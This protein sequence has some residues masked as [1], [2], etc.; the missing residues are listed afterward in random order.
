M[1]KERKLWL[2]RHLKWLMRTCPVLSSLVGTTTTAFFFFFT[3]LFYFLKGALTKGFFFLQFPPAHL[4][5]TVFAKNP[6]VWAWFAAA[7]RASPP[8]LPNPS[9]PSWQT[10]LRWSLGQIILLEDNPRKSSSATSCCGRRRVGVNAMWQ[11]VYLTAAPRTH[12][13]G[14]RAGGRMGREPRIWKLINTL[15]HDRAANVCWAEES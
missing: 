14:G 8:T 13:M 1:K 12:R 7:H 11:E 10:R 3:F 15:V 6:S 4:K 5:N 2:T 9:L